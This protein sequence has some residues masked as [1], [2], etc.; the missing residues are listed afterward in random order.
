[1]PPWISGGTYLGVACWAWPVG[2]CMQERLYVSAVY[3]GC[4][5]WSVVCLG[6]G[7]SVGVTEGTMYSSCPHV[8]WG[9]YKSL[10]EL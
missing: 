10:Y 6:I 8:L 9:L 1:V 7:G 4:C 5:L 3:V 2:R